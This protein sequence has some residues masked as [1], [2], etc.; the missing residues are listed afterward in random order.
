[1]ARS[2][3]PLT[4]KLAQRFYLDIDPSAE[5]AKKMAEVNEAH[6][7]LRDP[8]KRAKY[9]GWL[10]S[11]RDRRASDRFIRSNGD[12]RTAPPARRSGHPRAA[13]STSVATAAGRSGK[14]SALTPEFL[15]W[16]MHVP[17][18]RRFKD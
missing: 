5:A 8:E 15:E 18:G 13:W 7:V 11:H 17:A 4:R 1:M 16:L 3:A 9:D 10:V 2:S 6:G 14:S 12:S